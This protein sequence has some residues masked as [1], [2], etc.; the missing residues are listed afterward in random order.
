MVVLQPVYHSPEC[1]TL[2][3]FSQSINLKFPILQI[4]QSLSFIPWLSVIFHAS[5]SST[6]IY[7]AHLI[8]QSVNHSVI[9]GRIMPRQVKWGHDCCCWDRSWKE[10]IEIRC[11]FVFILL[12]AFWNSGFN[13]LKRSCSYQL[14]FYGTSVCVCVCVCVCRYLMLTVYLLRSSHRCWNIASSLKDLR[15]SI[16]RYAEKV[17][18]AISASKVNV[19]MRILYQCKGMCTVVSNES[20]EQQMA[21]LPQSLV[22]F[23][24]KRKTLSV[25]KKPVCCW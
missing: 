15:N 13:K 5:D 14:S 1:M 3:F 6:V 16:L 20:I 23:K 22:S 18:W 24:I 12:C 19:F 10:N 11:Q 9:P 17:F 7:Q 25:L 8:F 4:H 21:H 2:D